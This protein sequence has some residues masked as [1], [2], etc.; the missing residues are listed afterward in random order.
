MPK[1]HQRLNIQAQNL[2]HEIHNSAVSGVDSGHGESTVKEITTIIERN[3]FT[4]EKT[5]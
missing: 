5:H 3:N 4:E 2:H 1:I